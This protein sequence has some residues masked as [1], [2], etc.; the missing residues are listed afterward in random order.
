[1][2]GSEGLGRGRSGRGEDCEVTNG[3]PL[4]RGEDCEDKGEPLGRG[5]DCE[6]TKGEPL[7]RGDDCEEH[8]GE[9]DRCDV[10][11]DV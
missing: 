2:G 8:K 10:C 11:C 1:L 6:V 3:E 4:V 9:R 5:E 7:G